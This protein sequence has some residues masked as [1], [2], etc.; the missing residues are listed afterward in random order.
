MR[1]STLRLVVALVLF[2]C[3][4]LF[5]RYYEFDLPVWS[6]LTGNNAV[7]PALLH[8]QGEFVESHLGTTREPDG[9]LTLRLIAE[10]YLFV[11]HCVLVPAETPIR[12]R[13]TSADAV[14]LLFFAG[15]TYKLRAVRGTVNEGRFEFPHPGVYSMP[16][17]EFCGAGHYAMRSRLVAVARDQFPSLK[18]GE[19]ASCGPR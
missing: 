3:V 5:M 10:Q 2:T 4:F 1:S 7:D 13:I 19:I 12:V 17:H 16:C 15:T 14:H 6:Y 18:P 11:P 8:L 9:S